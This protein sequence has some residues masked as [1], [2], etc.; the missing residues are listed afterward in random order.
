MN[1]G[2]KVQWDP[3]G[4]LHVLCDNLCTNHTTKSAMIHLELYRQQK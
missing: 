3:Q 4:N 2:Q 1:S